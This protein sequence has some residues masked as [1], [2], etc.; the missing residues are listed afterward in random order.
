MLRAFNEVFAAIANEGVAG[1]VA[2]PFASQGGQAVP[3]LAVQGV[4]FG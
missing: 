3:V 1:V 2:M 4:L